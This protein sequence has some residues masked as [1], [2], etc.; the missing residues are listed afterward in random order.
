[1]CAI[2]RGLQICPNE[3]T[4][5]L[6]FFGQILSCGYGLS[7]WPVPVLSAIGTMI[8]AELGDASEYVWFVP[9]CR[10]MGALAVTGFV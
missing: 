6:F 1:M 9:V 3:L 4:C 2:V 8:S 10:S 5:R 7:F